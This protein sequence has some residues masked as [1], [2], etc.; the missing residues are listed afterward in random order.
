[1]TNKQWVILD[2]VLLGI[3]ILGSLTFIQFVLLK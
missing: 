2:L 1:M 3:F